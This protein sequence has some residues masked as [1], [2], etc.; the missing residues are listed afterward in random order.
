MYWEI[1]K[2]F[3]TINA[4]SPWSAW[5]VT[6]W[7]CYWRN[8]WEFA[9]P[10]IIF[11]SQL[12]GTSANYCV[13]YSANVSFYFYSLVCSEL[14]AT[15]YQLANEGFFS[16]LPCEPNECFLSSVKAFTT[17]VLY[18]PPD[19]GVTYST[20]VKLW[21]ESCP[22][23]EEVTVRSLTTVKTI[24]ILNKYMVGNQS[25]TALPKD[26]YSKFQQFLAASNH[27]SNRTVNIPKSY[28]CTTVVILYYIVNQH[29]RNTFS[30]SVC[31]QTKS[32]N[33]NSQPSFLAPAC[34]GC[35]RSHWTFQSRLNNS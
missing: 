20:A 32:C 10:P 6:N 9:Y 26:I 23:Y 34:S 5:V 30:L 27:G 18:V 29:D 25:L 15:R 19:S 7:R 1:Q 2:C 4:I 16:Y 12:N 8:I 3:W 13:M 35:Y 24:W 28:Y 21:S 31:A 11:S 33:Q 22:L 17:P 14:M